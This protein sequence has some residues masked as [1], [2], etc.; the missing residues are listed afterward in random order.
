MS[1]FDPLPPS[2]KLPIIADMK[3]PPPTYLALAVVA[4]AVLAVLFAGVGGFVS[5]PSARTLLA[6]GAAFW[7][8]MIIV[9]W[10]FFSATQNLSRAAGSGISAAL[11]A[12]V[13]MCYG[14][15]FSPESDLTGLLGNTFGGAAIGCLTY[16]LQ[17]V[18]RG[19]L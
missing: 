10:T 6:A 1:L 16:W 12:L 8:A 14:L 17:L 9:P 13:G 19:P 2:D 15:C 3:L 18:R 11:G 7:L 4:F 5:E